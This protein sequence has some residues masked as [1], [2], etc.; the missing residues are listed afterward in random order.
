P[1]QWSF[2][3]PLPLPWLGF[4]A[5]RTRVLFEQGLPHRE[6]LSWRALG[7]L[8]LGLGTFMEAAC[9]HHSSGSLLV[10]DALVSIGRE[11]PPVFNLDPTPLL[12]HARDRGDEPLNDTADQRRR[13][14]W[15]LA[16]FASYLRPASLQ[17]PTLAEIGR[18]ALAMA[19]TGSLCSSPELLGSTMVCT[20][21]WI[22][23]SWPKARR[24]AAVGATGAY[25]SRP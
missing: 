15:R 20:G 11:P 13:G 21:P 2:P 6:E 24:T 22:A 18:T 9:L 25:S 1:G 16:L 14:W 23:S 19:G 5:D 17:V 4:P 12:F 7:P 3:L 10:T 8:N